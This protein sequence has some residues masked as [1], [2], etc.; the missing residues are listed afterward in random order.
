MILAAVPHLAVLKIQNNT[1]TV[2]DSVELTYDDDISIKVK[3]I[4]PSCNKITG[5][6]T[7][8]TVS[9]LKMHVS[10]QEYLVKNALPKGYC[11]TITINIRNFEKDF[12]NFTV[13]EE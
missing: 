10:G 12:C 8:N 9:N 5:L 2:L 11:N 13:S 6:S 4:K 3:K 7:I 1:D